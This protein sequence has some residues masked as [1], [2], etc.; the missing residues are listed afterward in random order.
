[1]R[2]SEEFTKPDLTIAVARASPNF[3]PEAR[4]AVPGRLTRGSDLYLSWVMT[5]LGARDDPRPSRSAMPPHGV[6][7]L[8]PLHLD[9]GG[10][11]HP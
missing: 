2:R 5:T 6:M 3:H 7:S 1:M 4:L 10:S 11:D 9:T 8:K